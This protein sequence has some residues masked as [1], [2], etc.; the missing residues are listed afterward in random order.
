MGFVSVKNWAVEV[1]RVC[2]DACR[3]CCGCVLACVLSWVH[4]A[5][6]KLGVQLQSVCGWLVWVLMTVQNEK[7]EL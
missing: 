1:W 2:F 7:K 3:R 6:E 5:A 4:S